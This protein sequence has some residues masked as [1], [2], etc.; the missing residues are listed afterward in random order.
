MCEEGEMVFQVTNKGDSVMVLLRWDVRRGCKPMGTKFEEELAGVVSAVEG[1]REVVL[2]EL[3]VED[4]EGM[5]VFERREMAGMR[6]RELDGVDVEDLL[7][8]AD[9]AEDEDGRSSE[10]GSSSISEADSACRSSSS[11]LSSRPLG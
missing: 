10:D 7:L 5:L 4:R 1:E 11:S 8:L 9:V 3:G 2:V 6:G